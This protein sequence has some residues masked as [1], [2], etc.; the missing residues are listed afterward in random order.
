M[1]QIS[2]CNISNFRALLYSILVFQEVLDGKTVLLLSANNTFVC[3]SASFRVHHY[4]IKIFDFFL[5]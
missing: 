2:E 1:F 4:C 3:K 5:A